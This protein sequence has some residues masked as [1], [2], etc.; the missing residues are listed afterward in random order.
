MANIVL[1]AARAGFIGVAIDGRFRGERS[2]AGH[3]AAEYKA[4]IRE[5]LKSCQG[6]PCYFDTSWDVLRRV[7]YLVTR[8]DVDPAR[9]GLTG[10]SKGGIETYLAAAVDPRIAVAVP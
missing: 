9:I 3:G 10:I 5:A 6:H 2:R 7:D 4:A 8:P 1:K